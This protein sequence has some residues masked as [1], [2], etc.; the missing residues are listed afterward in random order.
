MQECNFLCLLEPRDMVLACR[1]FTIAEDI[2]L[3]GAKLEIP[4]GK[5]QPS[6]REVKTS[7]HLS[8]A[9]INVEWVIGLLKKKYMILKGELPVTMFKH[10]D[11]SDVANIDKILF[12]CGAL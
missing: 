11:D 3:F 8:R 12:V 1:G 5:S 6:Q 7:H 10:S 4:E 2:A 9:H